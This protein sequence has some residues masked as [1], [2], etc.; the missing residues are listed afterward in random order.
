MNFRWEKFWFTFIVNLCRFFCNFRKKGRRPK[1]TIYKHVSDKSKKWLS[2]DNSGILS[3]VVICLAPAHT[4][5]CRGLKYPLK[6]KYTIVV[7]SNRAGFLIFETFFGNTALYHKNWAAFAFDSTYW[8]QT[9]TERVRSQAL[10]FYRVF[11]Y[12]FDNNLCLK[13]CILTDCVPNQYRNVKMSDVTLS[14][15]MPL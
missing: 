10:W 9:F 1:W 3:V 5:L 12:I 8:Y 15:E 6:A 4:S 11:S 14:Y 7:D 2:V 13:Y